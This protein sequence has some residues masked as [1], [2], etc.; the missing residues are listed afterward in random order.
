M[1]INKPSFEEPRAKRQEGTGH[2]Y[3]VS[4]L[5]HYGAGPTQFHFGSSHYSREEDI[6]FFLNSDGSVVA[7]LKGG[8]KVWDWRS[9]E[10]FLNAELPRAESQYEEA[11]NRIIIPAVAP[12]A[13]G[14]NKGLLQ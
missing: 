11:E 12:T 10:A 14:R 1:G 4:G 6:A 2:N 3:R 8:H 7:L 9:V 13:N 5:V